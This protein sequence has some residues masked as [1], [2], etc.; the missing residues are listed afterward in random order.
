MVEIEIIAL[1]GCEELLPSYA[2]P[3]DAAVDLRCS[4]DFSLES[5]ERKAVP[6]GIKIALP[7]DW[8]GLVLPRSGISL[9]R[10]V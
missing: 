6:C 1:Q 3:T 8:A 7:Q 10:G 9:K 4:E 5:M 2:H